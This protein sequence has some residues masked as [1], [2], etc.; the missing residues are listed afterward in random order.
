MGGNRGDAAGPIGPGDHILLDDGDFLHRHLH[1][2]IAPGDHDAI[3]FPKYVVQVGDALAA[4]Q[5]GHDRGAAA[6]LVEIGA[7]VTDIFAGA[8]ERQRYPVHFLFDSELQGDLVAFGDDRHVDGHI[9][10]VDPF[11]RRKIAP[12]TDVGFDFEVRGYLQDFQADRSVGDVYQVAGT[13]AAQDFRFGERKEVRRT[14]VG[15]VDD[16]NFIP[17][18]Q[19]RRFRH[20]AQAEFVAAQVLQD[21]HGPVVFFGRCPH[22][23]Y[24]F[25]VLFQRTVG[26]IEAGDV[27][28][29]ADEAVQDFRGPG[30]WAYGGDNF[31][32]AHNVYLC[33]MVLYLFA[34]I[35]RR[36]NAPSY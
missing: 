11:V 26:E 29:G 23:R 12:I 30:C 36:S 28:A 8:H 15:F 5:L 21:G 18:V 19:L 25:G 3:H 20:V 16:R 1:A 31:S 33:S 4:L 7:G 27:H 6:E 35:T 13:H 2:E 34:I 24:N 22:V 32:L 17:K 10:E 9:G 14:G